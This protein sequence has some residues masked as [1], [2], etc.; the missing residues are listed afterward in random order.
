VRAAGSNGKIAKII[1]T[2]AETTR[3]VAKAKTIRRPIYA[4]IFD[5]FASLKRKYHVHRE[6]TSSGRLTARWKYL[7]PL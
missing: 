7:L 5:P 3:M 2:T 1:K 6:S 4:S